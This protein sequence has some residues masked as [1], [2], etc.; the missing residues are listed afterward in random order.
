MKEKNQKGREGSNFI[1]F[2]AFLILKFLFSSCCSEC[3]YAWQG[4]NSKF[5]CSV[6]ED[7]CIGRLD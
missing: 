4:A 7:K 3:H 6:A 1:V 2:Q 5:T